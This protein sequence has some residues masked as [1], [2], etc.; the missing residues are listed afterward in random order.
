MK[1][2][3]FQRSSL[4]KICVLGLV[5]S[6]FIN[7]KDYFLNIGLSI[8]PYYFFLVL[9]GIMLPP[10]NKAFIR[11]HN[12]KLLAYSFFFLLACF[13]T[14]FSPD[15]FNFSVVVSHL[16]FL[17]IQVLTF[18][19]LLRAFSYCRPVVI[20]KGLLRILPFI[21]V[22]PILLFA[23]QYNSY[24]GVRNQIVCGIFTGHDGIP[25][26]IGLFAD[27]NYFSLYMFSFL[28]IIYYLY[29]T[30]NL[31]LNVWNLFFIGIGVID[32]FLSFS[33]SAWGVVVLFVLMLIIV[34]RNRTLI[35][36]SIGIAIC[37]I[38]I[39]QILDTE[40]LTV[41][42]QRFEDT[43]EDGSSKER[44]FLLQKGLEA[45]I[46]FPF[47]VG[48]GNCSSFYASFYEPKL[49]H[50]DWIT[51]LIECGILGLLIYVL[52]WF[53]IFIS[54]NKIGK[55]ILF[56]IGLFCCTLTCYGYDPI[57]P[58]ALAFFSY[59]NNKVYE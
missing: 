51:V 59:Y 37:I 52:L 38:A 39:F 11:K 40:V 29:Q 24:L 15:I 27:P 13:G 5:L 26:L 4:I 58:L 55:V 3:I 14:F 42:M 17:L 35:W 16:L 41:I 48:I 50:N 33:R 18:Y 7:N 19:L 8:R 23:V 9:L 25:R 36:A 43:G 34:K 20:Y 32:I 49:A 6:M 47:G 54:S 44:I 56:S 30:Y 57:L 31:K 46:H 28:C 53:R 10:V 22:L 2:Y 21:T 1:R 45:P 12:F